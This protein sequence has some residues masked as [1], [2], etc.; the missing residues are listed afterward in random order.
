MLV[1]IDFFAFLCLTGREKSNGGKIT[2]IQPEL[3]ELRLLT[4]IQKI[5][6]KFF[7]S[8]NFGPRAKKFRNFFSQFYM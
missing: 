3:T 2:S 6:R 5:G 4:K 1:N 7:K 8:K